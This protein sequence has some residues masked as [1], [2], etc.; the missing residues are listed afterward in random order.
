MMMDDGFPL[1]PRTWGLGLHVLE[2]LHCLL[3]LGS[4]IGL[5]LL[6]VG[7]LLNE[8]CTRASNSWHLRMQ[9]LNI[10]RKEI[11][12]ICNPLMYSLCKQCQ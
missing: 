11:L 2:T 8:V 12:P 7:E 10:H 3:I 1:F 5:L 4:G 6:F 9:L